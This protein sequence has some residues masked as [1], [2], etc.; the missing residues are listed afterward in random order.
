[1][2]PFEISEFLAFFCP[3]FL[4][5]FCLHQQL[6]NIVSDVNTNDVISWHPRGECFIIIKKNKF[7]H[8]VLPRYFGKTN[9]K[10]FM[11]KL[12]R[13]GFRCVTHGQEAGAYYHKYFKRGQPRLLERI[14]CLHKKN[15]ANVHGHKM[16]CTKAHA[17]IPNGTTRSTGGSCSDVVETHGWEATNQ[18]SNDGIG[19]RASTFPQKVSIERR[20]QLFVQT[21]VL[22]VL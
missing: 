11:R 10:S 4:I 13:W 12:N 20:H 5:V 3:V 7:E 16:N 18:E 6:M 14:R 2:L 19:G 17:P 9:Y 8:D 22:P 1:M 21:F 15:T